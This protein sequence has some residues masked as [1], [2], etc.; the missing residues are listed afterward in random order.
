[1][2]G[3]EL[4][5]WGSAFYADNP[6]WPL[7]KIVAN[8]NTDMIGRSGPESG[9]DQVTVTPSYQHGKFSTMVRD[10]AGIAKKLGLGLASGD[11]Y[12]QRSDHYN[13]A[14]KGIPVVFF[15]D[16]EHEDYHQVTDHADKL[17][18]VKMERVARLAYWTGWMVAQANRRPAT[19]GKQKSW[20][21]SK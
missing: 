3:E 14:R 4:G 8:I 11:K 16:G 6:T 1:M 18:P 15:C 21:G 9:P 17:D 20:M 2:S 19:L 12:Y 7:K 10:A 5:L 13:F